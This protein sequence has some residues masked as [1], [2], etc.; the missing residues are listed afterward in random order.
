MIEKNKIINEN[1]NLYNLNL[2]MR[3]IK[4]LEKLSPINVDPYRLILLLQINSRLIIA[5][6]I[7]YQ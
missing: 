4:I 2:K 1:K 6:F 5:L 3:K 7:L